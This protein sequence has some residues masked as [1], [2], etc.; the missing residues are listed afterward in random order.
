MK[1]TSSPDIDFQ[2]D[3]ILHNANIGLGNGTFLFLLLIAEEGAPQQGPPEE[4]K[5]VKDPR[6]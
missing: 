2:N 1:D 4:Q 5:K 3:L 6:L